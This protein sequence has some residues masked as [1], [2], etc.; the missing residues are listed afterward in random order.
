MGALRISDDRTLPIESVTQAIGIVAKRR[1]GKSYTARRF[2]EQL[3]KAR[4][5]VVIADPKGDWWGI[6]F[7]ADGKSPG[8]PVTIL[9]GEHGD[10]P[11]TVD[12]GE[13]VARL[14]VEERV[15]LVLD[16]SQFRKSEVAR[17]M[18]AFMENLYRLKAKESNRTP[19]MFIVDEADAIMPQKPMQ[20]EE[21]ML[22]AGEDIVRRGGQRG[23]GCM[24]ITQRTAVLN[25]NVLTQCEM[26]IALRT[27]SPQDLKAMKAWID[28]HGTE[29]EGRAL[30]SSLPSL[31][32]GTAWFWSPGWPTSAGIFQEVKVLPIETFDSGATPKSGERRFDPKNPA[33]IDLGK[34]Q[35]QMAATIATARDN[36]PKELKKTIAELRSQVAKKPA[37]MATAP[38]TAAIERAVNSALAKVRFEHEAVGL[39]AKNFVA[40]YRHLLGGMTK[41]LENLAS[42][43]SDWEATAKKIRPVSPTRP[44]SVAPQTAALG[45]KGPAHETDTGIRK[46]E[47]RILDGLAA[48][49]A[50]GIM[51]ARRPN[52]A[53]FAGY[54]ENGHFNNMVGHLRGLGVVHYP[55]DGL[56]A[57]TD[58]LFP[59]GLA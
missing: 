19:L 55:S 20:G 30:M 38:D 15:N 59:P 18:T 13:V 24:L 29:E 22:G 32:V 52:V 50:L 8:L 56:V 27:I 21:R 37:P 36:D 11:L 51:A 16:L 31:P 28:V 58:V 48:F 6:R 40:H 45:R 44:L 53:F 41:E 34:L 12:A 43:F 57:A 7:A 49:E 26:L 33:D 46:G 42:T 54:S 5:Q 2:A 23:L 39:A 10:L 47:Q 35:A 4:Q 9:G 17:F 25:K 14:V 3:I 1:V